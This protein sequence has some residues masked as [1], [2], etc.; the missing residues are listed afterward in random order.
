MQEFIKEYLSNLQPYMIIRKLQQESKE[1]YVCVID[2]LYSV[3]VYIKVDNK[4][5]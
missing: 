4:Q 1:S 2:T 5:F 3:S